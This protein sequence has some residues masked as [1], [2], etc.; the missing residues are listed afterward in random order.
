M[1]KNSP[2][3]T[4]ESIADGSDSQIVCELILIKHFFLSQ[5]FQ[6]SSLWCLFCLALV[7]CKSLISAETIIIQSF[8]KYFLYR[9]SSQLSTILNYHIQISVLNKLQSAESKT[10]QGYG[11][12]GLTKV[13]STVRFLDRELDSLLTD[14]HD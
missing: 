14:M 5:H 13:R 7:Y 8:S 1:L 6:F 12:P 10:L 3:N 9:R 11:L 2:N 4:L